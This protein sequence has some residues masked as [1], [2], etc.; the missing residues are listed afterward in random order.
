MNDD[1]TSHAGGSGKED[2]VQ[3]EGNYEAAR[4]FDKASAEFVRSH[5]VEKLARNAAPRSPAEAERL[6][7]AEEEGRSHSKGEDEGEDVQSSQ[8][9]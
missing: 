7:D 2:G 9:D 4:R 6:R 8:G 1:K 5:D 3:G